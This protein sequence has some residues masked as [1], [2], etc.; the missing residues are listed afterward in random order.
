M[1]NTTLVRKKYFRIMYRNNIQQ[2]YYTVS[3]K[4]S[5]KKAVEEFKENNP[6]CEIYRIDT[7]N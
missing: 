2:P 7:I 1:E 4:S 6:N 5:K 3:S